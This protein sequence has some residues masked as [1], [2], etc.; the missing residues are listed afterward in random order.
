MDHQIMT[1][2]AV[3]CEA[4][5]AIASGHTCNPFAPDTAAHDLWDEAL[6]QVREEQRQ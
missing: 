4:R 5:A 6:R 1:I 3:R 2:T